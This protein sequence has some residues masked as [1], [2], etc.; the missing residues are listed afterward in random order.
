LPAPFSTSFAVLLT[1]YLGG[2]VATHVR[3]TGPWFNILFPVIFGCFAWG[4][5]WTDAYKSC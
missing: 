5:L 4:G 1:G 2:T 3:V